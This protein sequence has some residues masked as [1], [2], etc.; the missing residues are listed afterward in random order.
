[1][2]LAA[3][4]LH[5]RQ[6]PLL[7]PEITKTHFNLSGELMNVTLIITQFGESFRCVR[8]VAN[9]SLVTSSRFSARTSAA[10]TGWISVKFG[11]G[12]FYE[13]LSR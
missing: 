7:W 1:M 8:I 11:I 12:D 5:T 3:N 9:I 2:R 13:N 6:I 4:T 10:P